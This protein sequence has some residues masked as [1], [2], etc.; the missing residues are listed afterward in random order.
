MQKEDGRA[1]HGCDAIGVMAFRLAPPRPAALAPTAMAATSQPDAT[2]AAL[3]A[4][5]RGGNAVDAAARSR[6]RA[7]R[8]R[9]D[10]D[11]VRRRR[12]RARLGRR[13]APRPRRGRAGAA[14]RRSAGARRRHRA[15][16]GDGAGR[17]GGLGGSRGPLRPARPRHA[18][19]R[20]DR[21][22]GAGLRGRPDHGGRAGRTARASS[23]RLRARATASDCPSSARRCAASPRTG[24]TLLYRGEVGR[25]IAG[26]TWLD[27]EDLAAYEPALGRAA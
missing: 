27:E 4:L 14:R 16:L 10:V 26:C 7:L 13:A 22:C 25:A 15:D 11:R 20:R 19:R 5:E 23:A 2:A 1:R 21:R 12:V 6:G 9:A 3:R 8:H 18:A 17:G 24:P